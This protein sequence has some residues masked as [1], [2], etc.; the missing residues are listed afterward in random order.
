M[1]IICHFYFFRNFIS[2]KILS[3]FRGSVTNNNGL[4]IGWLNLLALLL[5]LR[6]IKTAHNQWPSKTHSIPYWTTSVFSFTVTNLILI[7]ESVTSS[8]SVVRWLTLHSWTL[9]CSYEWLKWLHES[10]LFYNSGRTED[11]PPP[12]NIRLLA[13][14]SSVATKRVSI[15]WQRFDFY[16]RVRCYETRF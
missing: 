11:R 12:R 8:A 2:L 5:Q 6:P 1:R 14:V 4:W 3:W 10:T 15:S 16:K 7:Y 13:S 9:N